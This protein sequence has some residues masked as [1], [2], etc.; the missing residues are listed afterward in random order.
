L[1]DVEALLQAL[2][3][4][5]KALL[6]AGADPFSL[7]GV[8]RLGLPPIRLTDGHAGARA[9]RHTGAEGDLAWEVWGIV[10]GT[11][12]S[13]PCGSAVGATWDPELAEQLGA[14]VGK[15]AR[16][17]GCRG[18]LAPT[19]N[20][21]RALLAGRNFECYSEDPLLSGKLAAAY[22]RGAQSQGV[23]ATVKHLVGNEAEFERDSMSSVI[24]E[25]TLR[26]LYLLPFE[27]A[28]REGGALA[29]MTS[30][31]RLNGLWVTEH[32]ELLT[33]VLRDEWG[34][35]GL[36]MTDWGGVVNASTSLAAGVDLEMPGPGQALGA[37]V[38]E[39]IEQ[40]LVDKADLDAAV[41]RLLTAL[42]KAGA[43]EGPTL[44]AEEVAPAQ[45]AV[46]RT[47]AADASVLLKNDGL[48]PL[49]PEALKSLAVL[50]EPA[51]QA[52]IGGGGSSQ[53]VPHRV[54]RPLAALTEALG[55]EVAVTYERGCEA[56]LAPARVGGPAL[57]APEG[58]TTE[59]FAGTSLDGRTLF[60]RRL[61]TLHF[62][63]LGTF[64][65]GYPAGSW[66]VRVRGTV[67]PEET[68]TRRLVLVT[69]GQTRVYL[70]GDLVFEGAMLPGVPPG[71]SFL[72][73]DRVTFDVELTAGVA[74]DLVV[75]Y[76]HPGG[77]F[78]MVRV[79]VRDVDAD[80]LL[81]R[82]VE[83]ARAAEVAVVF[84]GTDDE[85]ES[86]GYDR[87]FFSLPGRQ[88]D[89]VRR[90]A[91]ANPRTVVVVNSGAPV[92]LPWAD[93]VAAV[94]QV[95]FGGEELD[96]AVADVL[97]GLAEPGGR[98]P[99][100]IPKRL[101]HSPSH[102][103][104]PGENG[105]LRYGE[106]LFMGYRGYDHRAIEP[107]YAFGHGLSYTTFELGEPVL[108]A[109]ELEVGQELTIRVPVINTG[110]R[111]GS[112]V[113]Q[114]YVAPR[115]PR[116]VRPP[117]ELKAFAKVRLSAGEV[118]EATFVLEGRSFS[119]WDDG[120]E[121]WEREKE[122]VRS[123]ISVPASAAG[124]A[125]GWRVDPGDYDLLIGTASDRIHHRLTVTLR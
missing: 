72:R 95:W 124:S 47:A 42:D 107:R 65:E 79:G 48:L 106:G 71:G 85:W 38:V 13:I 31:N 52:A 108:S 56:T 32:A 74:A 64:S 101:E 40:G 7:R 60:R 16:D 87:P 117:K 10:T 43:L 94:L 37:R 90:I 91:A 70:N 17:C 28:V 18:L 55:S 33:T 22:I 8:E 36:V 104:F 4:E 99:L 51:R 81:D 14:I 119:Y 112:E 2:T 26:E 118:G 59:V 24:D 89:L 23:F 41:R 27:L 29:V 58:F 50:G 66:S 109:S 44:P 68:G 121:D 86:E 75:E 12:T 30:Y 96:G 97:T 123:N 3:L 45:R 54:A 105:V 62:T 76:V 92:D 69:T 35:E 113:V 80:Q 25:R 39:S 114:C 46:V 100:T 88:D 11:A 6:T 34:F 110:D 19:V 111:A 77:Q 125:R 49:R 20:L 73:D 115:S 83:A 1:A 122:R 61:S 120:P 21:H 15:D 103:N 116:L 9:A 102:D 84:V 78:G 82:A 67:L 53:L 63:Y 98:L 93:D 57:P 5:E